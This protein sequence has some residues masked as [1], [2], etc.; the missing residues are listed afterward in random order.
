M[1]RLWINKN[2]LT[3]QMIGT[4]KKE[5]E[6]D[7]VAT[8]KSFHSLTSKEKSRI[9]GT[10]LRVTTAKNQ[11]SLNELSTRTGNVL[12]TTFVALLNDIQ[13]S[14]ALKDGQPV[15]YGHNCVRD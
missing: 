11:E 5:F 8:A 14:A 10:V 4:G 3:L 9:T 12:N 1:R 13:E 15:K 6:K 7:F 2:G